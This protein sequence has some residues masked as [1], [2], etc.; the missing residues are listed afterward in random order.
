M[1]LQKMDYFERLK[2]SLNSNLTYVGHVG[3]KFNAKSRVILNCKF[4][5]QGDLFGNKWTPIVSSV[6][7]G[8]GCPKCAGKYRYTKDELIQKIEAKGYQ[9]INFIGDFKG[10]STKVN[11]KCPKHGEGADFDTLWEP[12]VNNLLNHNKGCPKCAGVYK[13][14][15]AE[16]I[17]VVNSSPYEFLTFNSKLKGN[18]TKVVVSCSVHGRGDLFNSPWLPTLDYISSGGGCPK[19]AGLYSYGKDEYIQLVENTSGYKFIEFINPFKVIHTR[20]NLRCSVHGNGKSFGTPWLPTI[21]NILR[22]GA[23]PKCQNRYV[24]SQNEIVD[25]IGKVTE[26]KFIKF[27]SD[28]SLGVKSR[29][30]VECPNHN[31]EEK[32]FSQWNTTPDYLFNG[33]GCPSCAE[34]GFNKSKGAYFYLQNLYQADDL[35]GLKYGITNRDPKARMYQQNAKSVL[36]HNLVSSLY[37]DD[38]S[39]IYEFEKS[40]HNHFK[41]LGINSFISKEIM[42]DGYTETVAVNYR[43]YILTEISKFT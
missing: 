4:H 43:D 17:Q 38:G 37:S 32:R 19:C 16:W 11:L 10:I 36:R 31:S 15:E 24:Y 23:C 35:I 34:Y 3:D 40:I 20:I 2:N 25:K 22:G 12:N 33:N 5:G 42:P 27:V 13:R 29:V 8:F 7:S 39:K 14:T 30:I 6:I 21:N 1:L 9:F 41:E 28:S 26:Y 18:K